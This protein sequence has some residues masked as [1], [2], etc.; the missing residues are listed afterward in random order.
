MA[1]KPLS[2][3]RE[4][5]RRTARSGTFATVA[6]VLIDHELTHLDQS[7]TYG[8]PEKLESSLTVGSIVRI[9]FNRVDIDGVVIDVRANDQGIL[10]PISK[11]LKPSAYSESSIKL[12]TEVAKR[13]ATSVMKI[14][15]FFE[16]EKEVSVHERGPSQPNLRRVFLPE[17]SK[18]IPELAERIKRSA[19]SFLL[20]TPSLRE[21]V[22]L[23]EV[24]SRLIGER[25]IA[26]EQ[27][28]K[29]SGKERLGRVIVGTRGMIFTQALDLAELVIF[30]EGSEH[31]WERRSPYWNLRDVALMRTKLESLPITFI[32]GSPSS[33][34]ARLID[35]NYLEGGKVGKQFLKRRRFTN[36]PDSYHRTIR[37]GIEKGSVLV[38]VASKSYINSFAC[39]KCNTRPK[40]ECGFPLKMKSQR[41]IL[42]TICGNTNAQLRCRECNGIEFIALAKGI[43]RVKEEFSKSF[44]NIPIYISTAEKDISTFAPNSIVVSTPGVEPRMVRYEGLVLLDG[45]SRMN[46]PTLRSEELL[47]NHW[48]RLVALTTED[49]SVYSS[50]PISNRISQALIAANPYRFTSSLLRER[51]ET[52][53]PPYYRVIQV[54]GDGLSTLAEKI[55]AE[56]P[57]VEISKISKSGELIIRAEVGNSQEVISA[58]HSLSKYRAASSKSYLELEIDPH[59]I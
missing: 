27:W 59:D 57:G 23:M 31:Y 37:A 12:A 45:V 50:L 13:Y 17:S 38:S 47:A 36:A 52:K 14:L 34:V 40:C 20:F 9:P 4:K 22:D 3:K 48:L 1:A 11:I 28:Q 46:R 32:S 41:E 55:T 51:K 2:L 58:L 39:K 25:A 33:E 6:D 7:F 35:S 53:L 19:G 29:L 44:P 18:T 42:C 10:K 8:V 5:A 21:S 24:L 54:K 49:A 26:Y 43:E 30:D 15:K 16:K 56:F